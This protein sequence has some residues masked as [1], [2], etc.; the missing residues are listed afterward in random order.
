MRWIAASGLLLSGAVP[1]DQAARALFEKLA[2]RIRAARTL[3]VEFKSV[4]E[5]G[6][7]SGRI[8]VK[9]NDRCV[10]EMDD[11]PEDG[12]EAQSFTVVS[13]GRRV[14]VTGGKVPARSA[15]PAEV[16][17]EIRRELITNLA[18]DLFSVEVE[19]DPDVSPLRPPV[20]GPVRDGGTATVA[21]RS[22]RVLEYEI[23]HFWSEDEKEVEAVRF[24]IDPSGPVPVRAEGGMGEGGNWTWTYSKFEVDVELPDSEFSFQSDVRLAR[25]RAG[26]L[27]RSA[28]LFSS[29]TGRLPRSTAELVKRPADLA[30]GVFWPRGGFVLGGVLPDDTLPA[31]LA[32]PSRRAVGGPTDRLQNHYDARV[33]LHLMAAAVRAFQET[34]GSLPRK[35]SVLWERPEWAAVWPEGG[36][37]PRLPEDPWGE[38][39]RILSDEG[40]V[41]VQVQKPSERTLSSHVLT[42]AERAS[43]VETALPLVTA[44]DREAMAKLVDRLADDDLETREEARK[45]LKR[46]E[47]LISPV[48]D[49]RLK[50]EKDSFAV[51]WLRTARSS[52]KK[53]PPVWAAELVGLRV[54]VGETGQAEDAIHGERIAVAVLK[55]IATA[56]ADFRSNDRDG[57]KI[58]DFWTAD[59]AGLYCMTSSRVKGND[60][61]P[62]KLIEL[63]TAAADAAP[64]KAGVAGGEYAGIDRFTSRQPR[65]GYLF[66]VLKSDLHV[67]QLYAVDTGGFPAMGAVH[68]NSRFGVCAYPEEY[69][70]GGFRT[71]IINEGNTIFWKDTGGRPATDWPRDPDLKAEWNREDR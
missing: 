53:R 57:N 47:L 43:L 11:R 23:T 70:I 56:Q 26:Q 64:L 62:M 44:E 59:V 22:V 45:D 10:Y 12:E 4:Y 58:S 7:S 41:R 2:K 13:D 50:G 42:P 49:A 3:S 68:N 33:E 21:G 19:D 55:T 65:D 34:Y 38:P 35:K 1:D 15:E 52:V 61:P 6:S 40:W 8:L 63:S 30:L 69:G 28:E 17:R 39:Y 16:I 60:D 54:T 24:F 27:A 32:P 66:R 29:F 51:R 31:D 18:S 46:W 5:G 67:G 48:L 20:M 36:W 9:G 25:A 37:I 14:V 71:Y